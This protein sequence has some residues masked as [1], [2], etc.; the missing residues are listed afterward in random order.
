M[1]ERFL[2]EPQRQASQQLHPPAM[3]QLSAPESPPAP[4]QPPSSL[5][6]KRATLLKQQ[7]SGSAASGGGG[8]LAPRRAVGFKASFRKSF[9]RLART[10]LRSFRRAGFQFRSILFVLVDN[11]VCI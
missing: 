2:D 1:H 10:D 5:A 9:R 11:F 7:S 8:Q 3:A 4:V 6:Q